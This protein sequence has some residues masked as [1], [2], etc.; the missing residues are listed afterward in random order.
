[1]FSKDERFK[2]YSYETCTLENE[3]E[4]ENLILKVSLMRVTGYGGIT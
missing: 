4:A 3:P 1:M 2:C